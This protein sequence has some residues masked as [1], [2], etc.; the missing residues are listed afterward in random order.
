MLQNYFSCLS[1]RI[2]FIASFLF[3]VVYQPDLLDLS[4]NKSIFFSQTITAHV[5]YEKGDMI[6]VQLLN[7]DSVNQAKEKILNAIYKV[8]NIACDVVI[9]EKRKCICCLR[10]CWCKSFQKAF[11]ILYLICWF[12]R[13]NI[14][15][16]Y[17]ACESFSRLNVH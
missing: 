7:C 4:L 17:Q 1:P 14:S 15:W 10:S 13:C 8:C 9:I 12:V 5:E 3:L 6:Q 2:Q 16:P 11:T